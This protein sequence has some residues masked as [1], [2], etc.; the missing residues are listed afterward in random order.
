MKKLLT[1]YT[2]TSVGLSVKTGVLNH[3]QNAYTEIEV[4]LAQALVGEDYST[5]TPYA[6][7]GCVN[8]GSGLNYVISA[9]A[10]LYNGVIYM[11]P[12]ATFTASVGQ[13]GVVT[14]TTSFVTGTDSDPVKHS[15]GNSYNILE[16]KKMV[17]TANTTG[18]GTFDYSTIKFTNI[19]T[20][21][22][23]NAFYSTVA[24]PQYRRD[25][26]GRIYTEGTIQ[27][28][29]SSAEG[30]TLFTYPSGARPPAAFN[31]VTTVFSPSVGYSYG[32]AQI[33]VNTNGTVVFN[34]YYD[35]GGAGLSGK[36]FVLNQ[37]PVF[38]NK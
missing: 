18:A 31:F 30:D 32:F 2:S 26:N 33:T 20:S 37:F 15:D 10:I 36:R 16:D 3:L 27:A 11:M 38:Y 13:V 17:V 12:A 35:I 21:I 8:T 19:T 34:D 5:S 24:Q 4:K 28:G 23:Q 14:L 29:A 7:W 9:G 6:L 25:L 22:T 1:T